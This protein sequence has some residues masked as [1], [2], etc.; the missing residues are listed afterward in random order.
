MLVGPINDTKVV[1]I[2]FLYNE[3]D[4]QLKSL[5]QSSEQTPTFVPESKKESFNDSIPKHSNPIEL[6]QNKLKIFLFI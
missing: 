4:G 3:V 1:E 2:A 6:Q 5:Q